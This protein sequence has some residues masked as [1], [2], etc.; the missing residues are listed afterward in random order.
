MVLCA[1]VRTRYL[2]ER[3]EARADLFGKQLRLLPG[4]E[5]A[6]PAGLVEVDEVGID[7]RG[8]A[9]RSLEDLA[10]EDGE[11]NGEREFGGLLPCRQCGCASTVRRRPVPS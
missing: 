2:A 5:V 4:G 10:G 6:A 8:P 1:G 11:G 9:A 7:L 3:P